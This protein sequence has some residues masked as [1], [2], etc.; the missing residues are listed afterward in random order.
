MKIR[1]IGHAAFHFETADG[2]KIRTDPY[3]ES[4][5]LPISK[6]P[7]DVVTVSHDHFDHNAVPLV[8]GNP[9]VV[10]GAGEHTVKGI[11]ITGIGTFHD[12]V[13]GSKRGANTIFVFS[14][15][16]L[17]IAHLGDLGH[18]PTAEQAA[19]IGKVDVLCIP[20]GG[21]YT[22]DAAGATEVIAQLNPAIAIPMHYRVP[23]LQVG[24][25]PVDDFLSGKSDVV[26]LDELAITP[27]SLP[28]ATRIVVLEARP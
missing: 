20:V 19:E 15:D 8:P 12:E 10:K 24:I 6:L 9:E 13:G 21:V 18:P 16:G 26:R 2:V 3:D 23:G 4:V 17:R 27:E 7:A 22:L 25:G 1:W 5:G 14:A 28:E 11:T